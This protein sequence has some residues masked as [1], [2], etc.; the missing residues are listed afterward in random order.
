MGPS[1]KPCAWCKTAPAERVYCSQKCRQTAF[2]LRRR[3][4]PLVGPGEKGGLVFA[5]ADPP[6]PGLSS[7]YY[8][9]RENY[10]GEVDHQKLISEMTACVASGKWAGWALSSSSKALK[11]LLQW[12]PDGVSV[13]A[14]VKPIGVPPATLGRHCTWEPVLVFGG[15][16]RPPGVRDWLSAQPARGGGELPGR[17]PI[18]FCSWLFQLLGMIP[19]DRVLDLFPGSGVV[20]RS[21]EELS[22]SSPLQEERQAS[23]AS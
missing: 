17:K 5:Y 23:Q 4:E 21:W 20:T 22:R 10:A 3:G 16:K 7:K 9:G 14:W 12:C 1:L 8:R 18:A 11:Q 2:R 19:G 15:R 6:Y 13:C